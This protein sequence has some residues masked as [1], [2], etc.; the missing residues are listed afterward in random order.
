MSAC[1]TAEKPPEF[2]SR[3][4]NVYAELPGASGGIGVHYD[5]RLKRG[6]M[7]GPGFKAGFGG[8]ALSLRSDSQ[9]LRARAGGVFFPLEFNYLKGSYRGSIV[10][11]A[12]LQP[13]YVGITH[14]RGE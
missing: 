3:Y 13:V 5:M 1:S 8:G 6:R 7:D 2:A 9:G 4:K 12:G 11:G 10:I 14:I